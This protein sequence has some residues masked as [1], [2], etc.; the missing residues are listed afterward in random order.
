MRDQ[1]LVTQTIFCESARAEQ[2][3]QTTLVGIFPDNINL[4][5]PPPSDDGE[6]GKPI[7]SSLCIYTRTR[8]P[9]NQQIAGSITFEFRSPSG[10]I[11]FTNTL[12][13]DAIEGYAADARDVGNEYVLLLTQ[14]ESSPF[15]VLEQGRFVVSAKYDGEE[16]FSGA[17]N[18]RF[19]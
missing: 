2:G 17:V 13:K 14:I 6:G 19:G 5:Q 15:P 1:R 9:L 16:Y 18:F 12:E 10:K 8:L 3:G 11:I 7:L 4:G